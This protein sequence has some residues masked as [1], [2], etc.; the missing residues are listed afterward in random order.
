MATWSTVR[1]LGL[2]LPETEEG[3]SYG[4]PALKVRGT[5]MARLRDEQTLVVKIDIDERDLLISS[6][7][8][9]Y[10]V[11]PH[12]RAYPLILVNLKTVSRSDLRELVEDAWRASA[13]KSLVSAYDGRG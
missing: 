9:V 12:Y 10:S 11:T 3:T 8:D 2:A 4:T 7:P 6:A 13:P 1:K 5:F